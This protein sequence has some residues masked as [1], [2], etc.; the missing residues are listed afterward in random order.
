M[1][2][3]EEIESRVGKVCKYTHRNPLDEKKFNLTM[4]IITNNNAIIAMICRQLRT[5][6]KSQ[7]LVAGVLSCPTENVY[8]VC[9]VAR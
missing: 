2:R 7:Q 3:G 5:N 8:G 1:R 6:N 9:Q 4:L